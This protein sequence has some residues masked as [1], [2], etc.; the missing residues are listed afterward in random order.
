MEKSGVNMTGQDMIIR[1]D[2][3]WNDQNKT[4]EV[5]AATVDMCYQQVEVC[6]YVRV[7]VCV[8]ILF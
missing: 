2:K 8:D 4:G 6:M 5:I 3:E 1:D 7:C